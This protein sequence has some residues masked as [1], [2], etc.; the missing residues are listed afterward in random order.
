MFILFEEMGDKADPGH[1]QGLSF[2]AVGNPQ[3]LS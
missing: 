2:K 1:L 3:V